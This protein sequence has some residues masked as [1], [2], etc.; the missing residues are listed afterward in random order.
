LLAQLARLWL[1]NID[2]IDTELNK[3]I[4]VYTNYYSALVTKALHIFD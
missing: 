2:T 4:A 1:Y 3:V